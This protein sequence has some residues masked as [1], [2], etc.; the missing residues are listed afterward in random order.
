MFRTTILE[1]K[2][3]NTMSDVAIISCGSYEDTEVQA[4]VERGVSLLGGAAKFVQPNEKIL[5]K[6]NWLSGDPP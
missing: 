5:L 1:Q 4:A 2:K 3:G 6:L